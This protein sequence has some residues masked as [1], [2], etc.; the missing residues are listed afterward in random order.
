MGSNPI[1]HPPNKPRTRVRGFLFGKSRRQAKGLSGRNGPKRKRPLCIAERASLLTWDC[2]PVILAP[3]PRRRRKHPLDYSASLMHRT[4]K[5]CD[6]HRGSFAPCK[7]S[8]LVK[9]Y[10]RSANDESDS[11]D[12]QK[13]APEDSLKNPPA[14]LNP[15]GIA[16]NPLSLVPFHI[17][18]LNSAPFQRGASNELSQ[19]ST[20]GTLHPEG[21][22]CH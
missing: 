16:L 12:V 21:Q 10:R 20:D 17:N 1:S 19:S 4:E 6:F 7:A 11:V 5:A 8:L 2:R 14:S 18:A 9:R 22:S 15:P 3:R 13:S